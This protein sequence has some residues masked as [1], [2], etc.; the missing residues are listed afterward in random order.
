V[1]S[2][3]EAIWRH[4]FRDTFRDFPNPSRLYAYEDEAGTMICAWPEGTVKPAIPAPYAEETFHGMEYAAAGEMIFNGMLAEGERLVAAVRDRYDGS[5]RNPWGEMEHGF[6]YARSMASYA[7][8]N[9]CSRLRLDLSRGLVG[10]DPVATGPF[11]C[12]FSAG[13]C[14]GMLER[15]GTVFRITISAGS[16]TLRRL[17]LGGRKAL[18]VRCDGRS[19]GHSQE[20]DEIVVLPEITLAAGG[21]LEI[22]TE[23]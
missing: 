8:L 7:L 3:L 13:G 20:G 15:S 16:L 12:F 19:I 18:E 5:R 14:W 1:R 22:T 23:D 4:N 9:A 2:A 21:S 11:G 6:N 17:W 10:F